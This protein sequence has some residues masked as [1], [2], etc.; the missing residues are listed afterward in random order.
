MNTHS[1]GLTRTSRVP[2]LRCLI[3]VIPLYLA[4]CFPLALASEPPLASPAAQGLPDRVTNHLGMAFVRIAAGDFMMGSPQ[5]EAGRRDDETRHRV[6]ISQDYYLQTTPVTQAQWL[7]LID[8]SPSYF[9]DCGPECPVDGL[10]PEWVEHYIRQL[11]SLEPDFRY[12]LPTEAE[13]EYAARAGT[14]TPFYFGHCPSAADG[15]MS[16]QQAVGDCTGFDRSSGPLPV[17]QY[18]P[19]PWG[20]YDMAGQTWEL[21]SDWYGPYPVT[22]VTD[23]QG[24]EAGNYKVLRGGSWHFYPRHARSA[25]RFQAV[26]EIAGFR[27]VLERKR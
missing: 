1:A 9:K 8:G 20:L 27:L 7:A 24:P 16:G 3:D 11:N 19:N 23:P 10:R 18:P 6:V 12:R 14:T 13:W 25:N 4:L 17:K 21:V 22:A 5:D 2:A 15:N 26:H